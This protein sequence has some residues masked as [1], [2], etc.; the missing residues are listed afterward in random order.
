MI[1][2]KKQKI[3]KPSE[4]EK[5]W[6]EDLIKRG[7]LGTKQSKEN[8][9]FFSLDIKPLSINSCFQ[10]R[11]FLNQRGKNYIE[12]CLWKMPK[13]EM[14]KGEVEVFIRIFVKNRLWA[15]DIDNCGKIILDCCVKKGLIEDDRFISCLHIA[16]FISDKD[17]VEI[18]IEKC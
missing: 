17:Y 8:N 10:G 5:E 3:L 15:F 6:G 11:R 12:I 16:K 2:T 4:L 9:I 14:I 18:E 13:K 1:K 7:V